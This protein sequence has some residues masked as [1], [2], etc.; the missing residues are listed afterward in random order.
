V[1]SIKAFVA[2][3]DIQ[4]FHQKYHH[5]SFSLVLLALSPLFFIITYQSYCQVYYKKFSFLLKF[6]SYI[7]TYFINVAQ[8]F[9]NPYYFFT[10]KIVACLSRQTVFGMIP[11]KTLLIDLQP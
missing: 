11:V 2:A 8:K 5:I 4:P 9:L 3:P 7:F 1:A 10:K 6:L